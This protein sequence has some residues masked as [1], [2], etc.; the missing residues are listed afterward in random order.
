MHGMYEGACGVLSC[1]HKVMTWG[2]SSRGANMARGG[3]WGCETAGGARPA[4]SA[5]AAANWGKQ[6]NVHVERAT[7]ACVAG[8]RLFWTEWREM[9]VGAFD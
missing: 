6:T 9:P 7:D 2:E 4:A 1:V 5:S 8:D 3:G